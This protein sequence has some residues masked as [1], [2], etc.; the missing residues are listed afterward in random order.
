[1]LEENVSDSIQQSD[2]QPPRLSVL[3][4]ALVYPCVKHPEQPGRYFGGVASSSHEVHVD[5]LLSRNWGEIVYPAPYKL[6]LNTSKR[7]IGGRCIFGGYV[8]LHYGHFLLESLSRI[9]ALAVCE[10]DTIVWCHIQKFEEFTD[11]QLDILK[12]WG[13]DRCNHVFSNDVLEFEELVIPE[14]GYRIQ[15]RANLHH[16]ELLGGL[17]ASP[18][19]PGKMLWL[20]R[21]MQSDKGGWI[22]EELIE[23]ML[24]AEG[25]TIYFPEEHSVI[26]QVKEI[27]SSERVAG[28]EGSA[29]HTLILCN[30]LSTRIDIFSRSH[31]FNDNYATIGMAKGLR[32][33]LHVSPVKILEKRKAVVRL[34]FVQPKY[35][36]NCLSQCESRLV[37]NKP[38]SLP[39]H[40][41]LFRDE[42]LS[43]SNKTKEEQ[44]VAGLRTTNNISLDECGIANNT[45]KGSEFK[46]ELGERKAGHNY[47]RNYE[48]LL[49]KF[50]NQSITL[51]ELGVG[52]DWNKGASL[53]MW[54]EYFSNA[55]IIGVDI[56]D[57]CRSEA[58]DKIEIK[59]GDLGDIGF[60]RTLQ[61]TEASVIIDDASHRWNHQI[62]AICELYPTLRSGGIYIVEDVNTSFVPMDSQYG[63]VGEPSGYEF[64]RGIADKVTSYFK[65][66]EDK[67]VY[68][69][70][71]RYIAEKTAVI[72]FSHSCCILVKK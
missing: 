64:L 21:S 6:H 23:R 5:S 60:L 11:A 13:L 34:E 10:L 53:R 55:Q 63:E 48:L 45:D 28:S 44:P 49:G 16:M 2:V 37:A 50:R 30:S 4:D 51:M 26:D 66:D 59:I 62:L 15:D 14:A 3:C 24:E 46:N 17:S 33:Y 36:L 18:I 32:Q 22:N 43:M 41:N 7:K 47:L 61:N 27:S 38:I 58:D 40:L 52:P 8:F 9:W 70:Y 67:S 25:W 65:Y 69:E 31:M 54:R 20:S 42:N 19:V 1:M 39:D 72:S 29:F 71:Q 35:L 57:S 56:R 12:I 68:T